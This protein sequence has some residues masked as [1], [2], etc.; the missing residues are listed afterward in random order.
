[1]WSVAISLILSNMAGDVYVDSKPFFFGEQ[2]YFLKYKKKNEI[3]KF[4]LNVTCFTK[5]HNIRNSYHLTA[6]QL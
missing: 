1:M 5:D 6:K 2:R 3:L 4:I